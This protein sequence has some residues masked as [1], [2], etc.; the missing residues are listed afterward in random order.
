MRIFT[1]VLSGLLVLFGLFLIVMHFRAKS[2]REDEEAYLATLRKNVTVSSGSFP[3]NGDMPVNCS[4]RG[5]EASPALAWEDD[6]P[7]A[8]SYVVLVTDYDMPTP[9]F[10]CLTYPIGFSTICPHRYTVFR[11]G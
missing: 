1:R 3:P 8:E 11:K 7:D 5:G 10:P 9:P 2:Q 6:V 4:C